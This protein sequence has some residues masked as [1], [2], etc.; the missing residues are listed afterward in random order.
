MSVRSVLVLANPYSGSGP[1]HK[2]VGRLE[3][4]LQDAGLDAR[5]VWSLEERDGRLRALDAE[6][7]CVVAAGGDGSIADVV[8]QMDAAGRLGVPFATLPVGNENLFAQ[9]FG[10]GLAPGPMVGAIRGGRTRAVDLARLRVEPGGCES[11]YTAKAEVDGRLLTLMASAGLDAEVIRRLDRWRKNLPDGRVRRVRRITYLPKIIGSVLGYRYPAIEL[12]ADGRAVRGH[13]A[14][15]FNL[16]RYGGGFDFAPDAR[17]DDG[18]LSWVV[19]RDPGLLRLLGYHL[20]V[21]RRT[22]LSSDR[23]AHGRAERVSLR[24]VGGRPAPVQADGDPAGPTPL[25]VEV[26]PGA[27]NVIDVTPTTGPGAG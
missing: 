6:T 4:A 18:R 23:V 9:E 8:N 19:F 20:K 7:S 5:V 11:D 14:Y 25:A 21:I 12:V 2:R 22:H 13:Q 27:L 10:F 15:V 26:L 17:A 16:P 1:N 3:A 24:S